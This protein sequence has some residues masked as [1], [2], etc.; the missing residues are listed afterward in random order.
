MECQSWLRQEEVIERNAG[1][2]TQNAAGIARC[3]KSR[4]QNTQHVEHNDIVARKVQL[5][6]QKSNHRDAG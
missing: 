2:R 5:Q 6:E 4:E 3:C 1:D